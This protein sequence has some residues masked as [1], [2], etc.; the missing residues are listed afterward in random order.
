M[1]RML[2]ETLE[3]DPG[4]VPIWAQGGAVSRAGRYILGPESGRGGMGRVH[5]A[6]DP[7]LKRVVAIKLLHSVDPVQT[8]RLMREAQAQARIEHP[9]ICKIF[10]VSAEAENPFIAMQYI[11]GRPLSEMRASLSLEELVHIVAEVAGALHAAH[12]AA[13]IHRD[14]KPSN[15]LVERTKDGHAVPFVLDFGLARTLSE[16]DL[17]LSWCFAGTPAFTSP[18]QAQGHPPSPSMDIY[19]LG[20]TL[21]AMLLGHPP[22]DALTVA[23][24]LSQHS[25]GILPP[26]RSENARIPRDLETI[27]LKCLDPDPQHRYDSAFAL[28]GDLRRWLAGESILARPASLTRR[29]RRWVHRHRPLSL[30]FATTLVMGGTFLGWSAWMRHD[31]RREVMSAQQIGIRVQTLENQLRIEH[32]LPPH[33]IRPALQHIRIQLR[34]LETRAA[35]DSGPVHYA[36]GRG[37]LSLKE[38]DLAGRHL[39][40]AWSSGFRT[41]EIIQ[42]MAILATERYAQAL[43]VR[44]SGPSTSPENLKNLRAQALDLWRQSS[45]DLLESPALGEAQIAFLDGQYD[46]ALAR[47]REAFQRAPWLYDALRLESLCWTMKAEPLLQRGERTLALEYLAHANKALEQALTI[48]RSDPQL[49]VD[50][51]QALTREAILDSEGGRPSLTTFQEAEAC[52]ATALAID[53]DHDGLW[54]SRLQTLSRKAVFMLSRGEDSRPLL[55]Q[56]IAHY[57][58]RHSGRPSTPQQRTALAHLHWLKAETEWRLGQDPSPDL[59]QAQ[60]LYPEDAL[61]RA[62]ILHLMAHR[63]MDRGQDPRRVIHEATAIVERH[64][65]AHPQ[66]AYPR[67]VL[68]DLCLT[69][70]Q[71]E[72]TWGRDP[73]ASLARGRQVLEQAVERNGA[74]AYPHFHLPLILALQGQA[75]LQEGLPDPVLTRTALTSAQR[76]VE[77][78]PDHFRSLRALTEVCLLEAAVARARGTDPAPAFAQARLALDRGQALNATDFRLWTLRARLELGLADLHRSSRRDPG[79]A[80]R[81]AETAAR[82]GLGFKRDCPELWLTLAQVSRTALQVSQSPR[83]KTIWRTQGLQAAAHALSLAPGHPQ[84]LALHKALSEVQAIP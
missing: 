78:R 66:A 51:I 80:L 82:K 73:Q 35:Q 19:S 7:M 84:G 57:A 76:A 2:D 41:P 69:L 27:T 68:G 46:R 40:T 83:D 3:T 32:L 31:A 74:I 33:D 23:V 39:E 25:Q 18:E 67:T 70:A 62:E 36:L 16:G 58:K 21:Y 43:T 28:E 50:R 52:F 5:L 53:P 37:Y 59:T 4:C 30:A 71:Y 11:P 1:V 8:L 47:S 60:A 38:F 81:A 22:H 75:A 13:L 24:L 45:P 56:A 42:A 79:P 17:T 15:I 48:G 65:K 12:R 34:D 63:D 20:A 44:D 6:W 14:M 10:E 49:H 26:M 64:L 77:L 55:A 29:T 54:E 9:H 72:Q 61:E